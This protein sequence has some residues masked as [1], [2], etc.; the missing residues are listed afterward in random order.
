[1]SRHRTLV[2]FVAAAVLFGTSFVGIKAAIGSIP[3][4]LFAA[5][6]VDV[7]AIVLLTLVAVRGGYW[8]PRSRADVLGVLA[9]AAFVLGANN[10][11]LFLGQQHATTGAAAVMYSLMPVVSP[12]FAMLLLDDERISAVDAVGILFGLAGVVVIVGPESALGG[13]SVGQALVVGAAL[14]VAFGT[15]LLKRV[16]PTIG[17]IPLTAWAM[18][19]AAVGIHAVSLGLGESPTQVAW[20]PTIVAAILYVGMPAT[21]AAYPVYF[22]L[23]AEAGPVRG[24]L[25]AY[26]MP[27]VAT[28]SGWAF[29]GES[30]S[31]GTILGFGVIVSGFLLVQR[32][33]VARI[34]GTTVRRPAETE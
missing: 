3:P 7:A 9:S 8:L 15:V 28:L 26:A 30:I 21:A 19:V 22:A 29:L 27:I 14:S 32:E 5:F 4:V 13:G 12:V 1:M 24:N 16:G 11:L 2:L 10:V 34:F 31:A 6:R 20:S 18:V 33:S 23:L 17:T 25:V